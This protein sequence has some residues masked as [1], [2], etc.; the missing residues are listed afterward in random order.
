MT[1]FVTHQETPDLLL[2]EALGQ[3][4][5]V[6]LFFLLFFKTLLSEQSLSRWWFGAKQ[7]CCQLD[8]LSR[9]SDGL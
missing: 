1:L 4:K 7:N 5:A 6:L 8:L 2:F 9:Q 3:K